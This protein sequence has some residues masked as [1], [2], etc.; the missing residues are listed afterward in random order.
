M[1]ETDVLTTVSAVIAGLR[2]PGPNWESMAS[3]VSNLAAEIGRQI[4]PGRM[5][6]GQPTPMMNQRACD[7]AGELESLETALLER[8]I[9]KA[10]EHAVAALRMVG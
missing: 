4:L 1:W 7:T 8:N 10:I 9:P 6:P 5:E 3:T 2:Q